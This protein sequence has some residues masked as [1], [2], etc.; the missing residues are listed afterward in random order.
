[1]RKKENKMSKPILYNIVNTL[2]NSVMDKMPEEV[3]QRDVAAA[4]VLGSVGTYGVTRGVQWLSEN[5]ADKI[6]PDFSTK[7][8]PAIEVASITAI[9]AA[10]LLYALFDPQGA[11]EIISQHPTYASGMAGVYVG[12]VAAALQDLN[13]QDSNKQDSKKIKVGNVLDNIKELFK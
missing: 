2:Y 8:L 4:F 6:I 10:P 13:K 5:V 9:T 1:M 7:Y 11:R 3:K 12:G